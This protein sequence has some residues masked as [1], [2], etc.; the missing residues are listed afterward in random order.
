MMVARRWLVRFVG[1]AA[2]CA[3]GWFCGCGE[4][5]ARQGGAP[6]VIASP[7]LRVA[8]WNVENLFDADDDPDNPGDDEFLPEGRAL[9]TEK[10]YRIKL[11]RLAEIIAEMRPDIIG[12]AE[13]ENRRVLEDL[14]QVLAEDF[15]CH[16]PEIVHREGNDY[17]GID[18]ALLSKYKPTETRWLMANPTAREMLYATF[19][20]GDTA[21]TLIMNHWKS[22]MVPAGMTQQDTDNMRIREARATRRAFESV[23]RG[24]PDA[25]VMVMGDFNDDVTSPILTESGALLLSRDAP[26]TNALALYNLSAGLPEEARGT[27]YYFP[28]KVWNSIDSMSVS[29]AMLD[30]ARGAWAVQ[31]GSY[32]IFKYPAHLNKG[33]GT[34]KSFRLI[35]PKDGAPYYIYGYSDHFPVMVTLERKTG[36]K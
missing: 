22:K 13:V 23:L 20:T 25:A 11:N 32:T 5:P 31:D 21:L 19:S 34:P 3:A 10:V 6:S 35:R 9:W 7:T 26:R 12:L 16:L 28:K 24:N 14:R 18:V 1:V 27:Y 17:R 30:P 4:A 33:S 2:L 36:R 15:D 29:A 8:A